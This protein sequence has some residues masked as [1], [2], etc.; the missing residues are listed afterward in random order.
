VA[1]TWEQLTEPE[2]IEDLRK[3]VQRLFGVAND[4]LE[5]VRTLSS[6]VQQNTETL[7]KVEEALEALRKPSPAA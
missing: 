5:R 3:D 6:A 7:K 1:K 2:K 4:F